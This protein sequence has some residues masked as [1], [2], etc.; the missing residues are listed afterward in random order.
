MELDNS[1]LF[2]LSEKIWKKNGIFEFY[3][4]AL[5]FWW[6][7]AIYMVVNTYVSERSCFFKCHFDEDWKKIKIHKILWLFSKHSLEKVNASD[8]KISEKEAF[9]HRFLFFNG[10]IKIFECVFK[11]LWLKIWGSIQI[12]LWRR[13]KFSFFSFFLDSRVW[14]FENELR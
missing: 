14:K 11:K 8:P 5:E 7:F 3:G 4:F 12:N 1:T 13:K 6:N 10:I 9:L 2:S